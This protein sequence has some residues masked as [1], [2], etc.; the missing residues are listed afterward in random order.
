MSW[1]YLALEHLRDQEDGSELLD[2][3]GWTPQEAA[4]FLKRWQQMQRE[5]GAP[6]AAGEQSRQLWEDQLRGLGLRPHATRLR[7]AA[8]T[9]DAGGNLRER[10]GQTAPPAEYR[11]QYRAFLKS[12]SRSD[13]EK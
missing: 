4:E 11:D 5:A 8:T 7:R 9:K 3:L 6:G 13:D 10:G 12:S 1:H 2:R